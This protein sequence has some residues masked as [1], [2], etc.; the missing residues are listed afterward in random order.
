M[1]YMQTS[2]KLLTLACLALP[3]IE[4]PAQAQ[5]YW[6]REQCLR[7]AEICRQNCRIEQLNCQ[8][9]CGNRYECV[10]VNCMPRIHP[11]IYVTCDSNPCFRL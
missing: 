8:R 2:I 7:A 3:F 6:R 9:A 4:S 11:C 5:S 1:R 10:R